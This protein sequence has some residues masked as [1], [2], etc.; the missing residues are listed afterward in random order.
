MSS[1]A[2]CTNSPRPPTA[3]ASQI[4]GLLMQSQGPRTALANL[5]RVMDKPVERPA[6]QVFIE[7]PQL[8]GEIEF[9]NVKFAYPGRGD[10]AALDGLSFKIAAGEKVALI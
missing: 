3:P 9:R 10:A 6:D 7:R 5:N 1:R 2:G 8:R 4:V